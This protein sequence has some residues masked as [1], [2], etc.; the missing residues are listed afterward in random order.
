MEKEHLRLLHGIQNMEFND[1]CVILMRCLKATSG[2]CS[3]KYSETHIPSGC[4]IDDK[5]KANYIHTWISI[6]FFP[7]PF[8]YSFFFPLSSLIVIL[9]SVTSG[10]FAMH[11]SSSK[12]FS[13]K[14]PWNDLGDV[15][16][17]TL[18]CL[19]AFLPIYVHFY[20]T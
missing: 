18:R 17:E 10:G 12:T 20:S 8:L 6:F 11:L 3:E 19:C 9:I 13:P 5:N 14:S 4:R 1:K 16:T 15:V 7:Q 2:K